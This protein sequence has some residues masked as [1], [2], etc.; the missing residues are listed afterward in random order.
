MGCGYYVS[1]A[2]G[3]SFEKVVLAM[4][5]TAATEYEVFA[6]KKAKI[7]SRFEVL[8]KKCWRLTQEKCQV[9]QNIRALNPPEDVDS[10][11]CRRNRRLRGRR[12]FGS[13]SRRRERQRYTVRTMAIVQPG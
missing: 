11:E 3:S 4:A 2:S 6:Q 12:C 7:Y 10:K 8:L 9:L 13:V 5:A 1:N